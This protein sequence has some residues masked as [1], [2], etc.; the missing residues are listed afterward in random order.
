M[1][2]VNGGGGG[3]SGRRGAPGG[4][5]GGA[6]LGDGRNEV[7]LHPGAICENVGDRG[8]LDRRLRNVG[9]LGRGVV[10]P[11]GDLV[12]IRHVTLGLGGQLRQG[13]V[14]VQTGHRGEAR[15]RD[16]LGVRG[17]DQ[18]IG[19]GGIAD[20][21]HLDV[22]CSAGVQGLALGAEDAAVG[23][24]QVAPLHAGLTRH[25]ADEEG[26]IGPLE[27]L[28][29]VIEDVDA[30]EVREGGVEQL[31][32]GALGGLDGL[33]DLEQTQ[34]DPLVGTEQGARGDAEEQRV[35]DISGGTGH[36]DVDGGV[37]HE[38]S[39]GMTYHSGREQCSPWHEP[40]ARG[41]G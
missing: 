3:R 15:G 9:V 2:V 14:V 30:A 8:A 38:D 21:E 17:S 13:A 41:R 37:G 40:T 26:D 4:D 25:G 23:G 34:V 33:R 39:F 35:T 5:D 32:R 20:H 1:D 24:Q 6:A 16:V 19:V 11:H 10:A 29:G 7:V 36:G 31:H 18:R 22:V 12:Q 28:L 27:G